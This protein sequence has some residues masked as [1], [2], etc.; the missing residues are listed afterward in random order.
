MSVGGLF[1]GPVVVVVPLVVV[2][3]VLV[4]PVDVVPVEVVPVDVAPVEVVPV[5]VVLVVLVPVAPV[6]VAP[7]EVEPVDVDG[8][9][10]VP[11]ETVKNLRYVF[12]RA[13][14]GRARSFTQPACTARR[15]TVPTFRTRCTFNVNEAEGELLSA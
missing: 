14:G 12:A 9:R 15:Q 3:L 13:C 11:L 5:E 7:V 1:V 6:P 2:P 10:N 8:G 4:V